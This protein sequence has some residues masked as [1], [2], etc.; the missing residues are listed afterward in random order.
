MIRSSLPSPRYLVMIAS[1]YFGI[2]AL[3]VLLGILASLAY[4]YPLLVSSFAG[5]LVSGMASAIFV[6]NNRASLNEACSTLFKVMGYHLHN[7]ALI[8]GREPLE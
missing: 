8:H 3:I 4:E 2:A 1:V 6:R 5:G 7:V